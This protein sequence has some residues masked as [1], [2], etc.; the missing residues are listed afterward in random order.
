ML[1]QFGFDGSVLLH[2]PY[3]VGQLLESY[4]RRRVWWVSAFGLSPVGVILF[5]DFRHLSGF[6]GKQHLPCCECCAGS[7]QPFGSRC[8][9]QQYLYLAEPEPTVTVSVLLD[10]AEQNVIE[11]GA[12]EQGLK[13]GAGLI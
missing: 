2:W 12:I 4:S 13:R 5:I 10:A 1:L 6:C 8:L 9:F 11:Q 7:S 3:G